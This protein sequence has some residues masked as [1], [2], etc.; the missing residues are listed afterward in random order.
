MLL[1]EKS[2]KYSMCYGS[3]Q[4]LLW[5]FSIVLLH[6]TFFEPRN[7]S[8][9]Y[10]DTSASEDEDGADADAGSPEKQNTS[11]FVI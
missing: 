1:V 5:K 7:D 3:I 10:S 8:S 4:K 11:C 2:Q 9:S 6:R